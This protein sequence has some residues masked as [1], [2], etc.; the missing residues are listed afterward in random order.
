MP[1][2]RFVVA[3]GVCWEV[4]SPCLSVPF[5]CFWALSLSN[6][7]FRSFTELEWA[8]GWDNNPPLNKEWKQQP[9]FGIWS[10]TSLQEL[11]LW[12][13]KRRN[14]QPQS[15]VLHISRHLHPANTHHQTQLRI[16][17]VLWWNPS[18][19]P[20]SWKS[21]ST[22]LSWC[23]SCPFSSSGLWH[24]SQPSKNQSSLISSYL[25]QIS[26]LSITPCNRPC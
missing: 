17:W 3:S 12:G 15:G 23:Q 21:S 20:P 1:W 8:D 7:K 16:R 9:V 26:P 19:V 22:N 18:V 25:I 11:F 5:L 2:Q 24:I 13:R 4:K 6:G 14:T 10:C